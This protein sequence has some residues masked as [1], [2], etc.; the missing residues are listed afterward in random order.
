MAI[1]SMYSLDVMRA[2]GAEHFVTH[3][4][5]DGYFDRVWS[6]NPLVG[7]QPGSSSGNAVGAPAVT[8]LSAAHT[9]IEAGSGASPRWSACPIW[10]SRAP[11]RNC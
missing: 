3:R 10:T 4:D 7:A 6:V 1:D 5:L 11:R 8:A 2:R 9:M